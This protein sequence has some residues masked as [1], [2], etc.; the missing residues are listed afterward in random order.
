[1]LKETY[2]DFTDIVKMAEELNGLS[3]KMFGVM[4]QYRYVI[5][6]S[7]FKELYDVQ[8][9]IN[10]SPTVNDIGYVEI[11]KTTGNQRSTFDDL[12]KYTHRDTDFLHSS[13]Q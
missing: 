11:K 2:G 12:N 8:K 10:L 1:M 3:K 7:F 13:L 6:R 5:Q 9:L 4:A